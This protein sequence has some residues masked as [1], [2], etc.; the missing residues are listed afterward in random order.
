[1]FSIR[2]VSRLTSIL[3]DFCRDGESVVAGRDSRKKIVEKPRQTELPQ[4]SRGQVPGDVVRI[5][6]EALAQIDEPHTDAGIEPT[7]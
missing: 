7:T 2:P 5:V 3:R 6:I 4:P 1:M